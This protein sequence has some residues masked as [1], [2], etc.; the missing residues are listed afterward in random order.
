ME[1]MPYSKIVAGMHPPP[2][3]M[4]SAH[5]LKLLLVWILS[6]CCYHYPWMDSGSTD[7]D[8]HASCSIPQR[9]FVGLRAVDLH[10]TMYIVQCA[11]ILYIVE[12]CMHVATK[13]DGDWWWSWELR[14]DAIMIR[15][16]F[17]IWMVATRC[18]FYFHGDN[19]STLVKNSLQT[20]FA[21]IICYK[22]CVKESVYQSRRCRQHCALKSG[23]FTEVAQR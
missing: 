17:L 6:R 18:G 21:L 2:I 5:G 10:T 19:M 20:L 15:W 12:S 4:V 16:W 22:T 11:C 1:N 3:L 13:H 14:D 9:R 23:P 7:H 8:V